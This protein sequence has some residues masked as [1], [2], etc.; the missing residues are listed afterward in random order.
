MADDAWLV[1]LGVIALGITALFFVARRA[2]TVCVLS[3]ERGKVRVSHGDLAPRILQDL[4]DVAA[5]PMVV[6]GVIRITRSGGRAQV[7]LS[8]AFTEPQAQQVRNVVGSVPLAMLASA[9]AS[10]GL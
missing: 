10:R 7:A 2:V 3:V 1:V 4:R 9:R 8:G 6:R 5:R